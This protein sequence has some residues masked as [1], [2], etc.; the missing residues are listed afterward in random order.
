MKVHFKGITDD[1]KLP[2]YKGRHV[3]TARLRL[4]IF[5]VFAIVSGLFFKTLW[6][7][8]L[9]IPLFVTS[10]FL[11]T[12]ISY[13]YI[14]KNK[15]LITFF[16]VEVAAD[17]L[18][19]T[20]VVYITGGSYSDYFILYLMYCL[21]AGSFYNDQVAAVAAGL[22]FLFYLSLLLSLYMSW[23]PQ[24]SQLT[25]LAT[26]DAHS[27]FSSV[28]LIVFTL[29]L[30]VIVY[31]TRI[32]NYFSRIKE[33]ALSQRNK[34]L[35]ALNLISSTIRGAMAP[36]KVIQQVLAGVIEGLGY[37]LCL[38]VIED[39]ISQRMHFFIPNQN[40]WILKIE[41]LTPFKL[42]DMSIPPGVSDSVF[43]SLRRNQ[44]LFREN[45]S[46]LT[47]SVEPK[48]P[49]G[50]AEKIQE[51]IGIKKFIIMPLVAEQK[52][53]GALIGVSR[54]EFVDETR[55][56]FLENFTN[57]A[58]LAIEGAQLFE[59]L[60]KQN[61]E[62]E[63]AN[64]IKS[65]FLAI[66]SHELR[67]PLTAIIG[68]SELLVEEVLGELT[69]EQKESLREVINNGEH[70]LHL[71]NSILDLAKIEAGKIELDIEPF[72]VSDL[73]NEIK[74]FI[75]PLIHKKNQQLVLSLDSELPIV[76]ADSRKIRQILLNLL[77]NAIKFTP[78]KGQ[79][80]MKLQYLKSIPKDLGYKEALKIL[81]C[82]KGYI[83]I[84]VSDNGIGI[85]ESDKEHIFNAFEQVDS[86]ITRQYQ[87]TGLGLALTKQF[88]ELHH[89]VIWVESGVNQGACFRIILPVECKKNLVKKH[90]KKDSDAL[91]NHA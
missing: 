56:G 50:L 4:V 74:F 47:Q 34:Q 39:K 16:L 12:G 22:S 48:W 63:Q 13:Y 58:A 51:E 23:I 21:A 80:E 65:E 36:Q 20:L 59:A 18:T 27:E 69:K 61:I 2:D 66:M 40:P 79:V 41:R 38:L 26:F 62:L 77:S 10:T 35:L 24:F 68:F 82:E 83:E 17:L 72:S 54:A 86:S 88:V 8:A 60:K 85:S 42:K 25:S 71:I 32:S 64:K 15:G 78:E 37:D 49:S 52:L 75:S 28:R 9:W 43:A 29:F 55:I 3:F 87:G 45:L 46:E 1:I 6:Q 73:V 14:L 81:P 84:E 70:L 57:H 30:P 53:M 19:I 67:T 89:G 7:E 91:M 31:A 5:I 11:I 44:V 33:R 76:Y 90:S